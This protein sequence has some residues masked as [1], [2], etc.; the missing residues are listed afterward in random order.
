MVIGEHLRMAIFGLRTP[1]FGRV[2]GDVALERK[3]DRQHFGALLGL[4]FLGVKRRVD[5]AS[6]IPNCRWIGGNG[7]SSTII[8]S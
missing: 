8:A 1:L 7:A 6:D 5:A 2:D 4:L 3:L